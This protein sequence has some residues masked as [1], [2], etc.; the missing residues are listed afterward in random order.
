MSEATPAAAVARQAVW[1]PIVLGLAMLGS[2]WFLAS[3]AVP[4]LGLD[5]ERFGE[6]WPRRGWLLAHIAG[7][8]VAPDDRGG[9]T[10]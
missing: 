6:Y 1:P 10:G 3:A 4:Y 5:P 8:M 7:G 9:P 2:V